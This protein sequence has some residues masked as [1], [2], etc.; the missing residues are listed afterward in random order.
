MIGLT[1]RA[2]RRDIQILEIYLRPIGPSTP[3]TTLVDSRP[4]FSIGFGRPSSTGN[5]R[6]Q[7][8]KW[9]IATARTSLLLMGLSPVE[10]GRQ[11]KVSRYAP[12]LGWV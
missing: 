11:A 10:I 2:G 8:S 6:I 9:H 4:A 5:M 3:A 1:P 12:V 7:A